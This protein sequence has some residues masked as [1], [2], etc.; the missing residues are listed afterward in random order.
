[1]KIQ[2]TVLMIAM[3]L[4]HGTAV[5]DFA[6]QPLK[7]SAEKIA[8]IEAARKAMGLPIR[9]DIEAA[10]KECTGK[11]KGCVR[12]ALIAKGLKVPTM[13]QMA[14]RK[15]R[16]DALNSCMRGDL[17]GQSQTAAACFEQIQAEKQQSSQ[18]LTETA[19]AQADSQGIV[20]PLTQ[21]VANVIPAY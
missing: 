20:E 17:T 10:V 11:E 18:S 5:A 2:S 9:A 21:T 8:E 1:M 13:E 3:L 7:P 12:E 19:S 4:T 15:A 14:E 16:M 6:E